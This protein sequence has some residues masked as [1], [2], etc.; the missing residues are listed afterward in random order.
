MAECHKGFAVHS[1]LCCR[2]QID[3]CF[4]HYDPAGGYT[5][6][7]LIRFVVSSYLE[8]TIQVEPAL[9]FCLCTLI[10]SA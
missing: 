9:Y 8:E 1:L 7:T 6:L 2:M 4:Q 5:F 3:L 10:M